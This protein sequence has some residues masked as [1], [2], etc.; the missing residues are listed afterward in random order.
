MY[1]VLYGVERYINIQ[2]GTQVY[3]V[4]WDIATTVQFFIDQRTG[5]WEGLETRVGENLIYERNL[6]LEVYKF[7]GGCMLSN[8]PYIADVILKAVK[9]I[10][11]TAGLVWLASF[12]GSQ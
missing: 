7:S 11:A 9:E 3:V 5:R 4:L 1:L 6:A 8:P 2:F 12:S 10:R